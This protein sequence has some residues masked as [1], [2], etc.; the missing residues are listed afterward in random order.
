MVCSLTE[1]AL[2]LAV[3]S[4][5]LTES[6]EA[7]VGCAKRTLASTC[8]SE[9]WGVKQRFDQSQN[10]LGVRVGSLLLGGQA[11]IPGEVPQDGHDLLEGEHGSEDASSLDLRIHQRAELVNPGQE[12]CGIPQGRGRGVDTALALAGPAPFL[13]VDHL[14]F[15]GVKSLDSAMRTVPRVL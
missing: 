10:G 5:C 7:Y 6:E 3:R 12:A 13:K 2:H 8:L 9:R 15:Q 11:F 4:S 1:I 14:S